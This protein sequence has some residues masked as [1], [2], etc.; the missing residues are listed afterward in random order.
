MT[1]HTETLY[2]DVWQNISLL[3]PEPAF[4]IQDTLT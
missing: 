4:S 1:E 3:Q 2:M